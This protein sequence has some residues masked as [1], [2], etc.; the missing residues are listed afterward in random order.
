MNQCVTLSKIV[1]LENKIILIFLF[2]LSTKVNT[3][4]GVKCLSTVI[5][6][7]EVRKTVFGNL[8]L[9]K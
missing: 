7:L 8:K 4:Q 2:I 6:H 3:I 9:E 1:K 5:V